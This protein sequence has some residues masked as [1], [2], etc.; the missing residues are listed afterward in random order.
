MDTEKCA[1]LL[2]A[3]EAGSLSGAADKLGY[4]PPA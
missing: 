2:A 4:T 1:V 3:L